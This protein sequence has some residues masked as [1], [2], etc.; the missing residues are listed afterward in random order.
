[1]HVIGKGILRFH[2]VYW[3]AFLLSAGQPLPTAICV[4]DY[5]TV[6]GH[7]ISTSTGNVPRLGDADF[8]MSAI[9]S[10]PS[11]P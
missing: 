5:L 7:K 8:T 10:R 2:A 1:V 3:P 6:S 11:W 9:S 4:H